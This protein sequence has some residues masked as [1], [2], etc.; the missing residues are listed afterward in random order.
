MPAKVAAMR[1]QFAAMPEN[2][3]G[4]KYELVDSLMPYTPPE[5]YQWNPKTGNLVEAKAKGGR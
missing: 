3:F 4:Y 2:G 5:T 1:N